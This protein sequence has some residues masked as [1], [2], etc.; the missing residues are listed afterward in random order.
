[1]ST[2]TE[3]RQ[4]VR[5]VLAKYLVQMSI[6]FDEGDLVEDLVD[7]TE[8]LVEQRAF[9]EFA[10][11]MERLPTAGSEPTAT[12]IRLLRDSARES[13]RDNQREGK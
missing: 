3:M 2:R 12:F 6:L 7:A 9:S 4:A 1:M 10:D 5:S 8:A 11:R 13:I